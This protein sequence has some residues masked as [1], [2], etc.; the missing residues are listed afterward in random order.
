MKSVRYFL[1]SFL[2]LSGT[3]YSENESNIWY[4]GDGAGI[5]FNSGN[6]VVIHDSQMSASEGCA[7][8]CDQNG[9]L[10]F[11]TNGISIWN[12]EHRIMPN[13]NG[14][15][16]HESATQSGV[17][18]PKPGDENFF[19]IFTVTHRELD[20]GFR[21]SL[22]DKRLDGGL[23][24]VTDEKNVLLFENTTEKI[25][26]VRHKNC[27]DKWVIAHE[28]ENNTFRAYKVTD[29]GIDMTPVISNVG[30]AHTRKQSDFDNTWDVNKR[31][32]MRFSPDGTRLALAICQDGIYEIFDFDNETG[33]FSNPLIVRTDS[34]A[35]AYGM[36]FSS[37]GSKF[38]FNSVQTEEITSNLYRKSAYI[39]QADLR[40]SNINASIVE[41]FSNERETRNQESFSQSYGAIQLA[42]DGKIYIARKYQHY[43]G[44]INYPNAKGLACGY[45]NE[46]IFLGEAEESIWGLPTFIQDNLYETSTIWFPDTLVSLSS[47]QISLP[48]YGMLSSGICGDLQLYFNAEL[49]FD[50]MLFYPESVTNGTIVNNYVNN[51]EQVLEIEG[52]EAVLGVDSTIILEV[53]GKP[54]LGET[55]VTE[56]KIEKFELTNSPVGNNLIN[57]TMKLYGDC[58]PDERRVTLNEPTIVRMSPNPASESVKVIIDSDERGKFAVEVYSAEGSLMETR[59]WTS[60]SGETTTI[61]INPSDY[62]SGMYRVVVKTPANINTLPLSIIK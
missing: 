28:W 57:G 61:H 14:L 2:L 29:N 55:D 17:I 60:F 35:F 6:A 43:L 3:L 16:G 62:T 15:M 48:V 21:Y 25:A 39:Y 58:N 8:I 54:L 27:I 36:E 9:D 22:V 47:K 59:E 53:I 5:D 40:A 4:F 13:G 45:D 7:T 37:D 31:G 10:L 44:V 46:G 52:I 30:T 20:D 41:L 24:D 32:Y 34:L 11:Y 12:R 49:R 33:K 51:G 56:L 18:V 50:A 38:Y 23:G 19:Y 42:P 26:A 1:L